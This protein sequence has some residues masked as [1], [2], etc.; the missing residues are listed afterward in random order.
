MTTSRPSISDAIN[1]QLI[2]F[3]PDVHEGILHFLIE[4]KDGRYKKCESP[5]KNVTRIFPMSFRRQFGRKWRQ[6][7]WNSYYISIEF[8]G[9]SMENTCHFDRI[10]CHTFI[11]F[12]YHFDGIQI[13][14]SF[15]KTT[16]KSL[17]ARFEPVTFLT[18]SPRLY[19]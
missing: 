15:K 7:P 13:W 11:S 2:S 3:I 19:P 14:I 4:N 16:K 6:I 12:S 18:S 8:H 9:I 10:W 17:S 5:G 1:T